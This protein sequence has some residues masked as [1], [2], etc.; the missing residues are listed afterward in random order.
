MFWSEHCP[1]RT[2][3][4]TH[5]RDPLDAAR[6]RDCHMS[7]F[8]GKVPDEMSPV[9][10]ERRLQGHS[11]REAGVP[12]EGESVGEQREPRMTFVGRWSPSPDAGL[13]TGVLTAK[14]KAYLQARKGFE[15]F[16]DSR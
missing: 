8:D 12:P 1:V 4:L 10:I 15:R 6:C 13:G 7:V 2:F 3:G 14:Q 11:T 9:D 16:L 5:T